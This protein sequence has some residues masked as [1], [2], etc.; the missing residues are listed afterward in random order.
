[1]ND[2]TATV[3]DIQRGSF[4]DGPGIRTTVFFKGCNLHC[5][6]CH[7]PEGLEKEPE[8]M[9]TPERCVGCGHCATATPYDADFLCPHGAKKICGRTYTLDGILREVQKDIRFYNASGGGVTL[10]GGECLLQIDFVEALLRACRE[11]GI[12]TAVD[13]AG[14]VPYE[15]FERILPYVDLFL[16]DVKC[17]D[18][19]KHRHFTGVDNKL[20]LD[21]LRRLLHAGA[22][23]CVRVPL[24]PTVNDTEEEMRA[25]KELVT[26]HGHLQGLELLPYH[27]M[28]EDKYAA[29]GKA[30]THF[31]VPSEDSVE[32]LKSILL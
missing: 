17:A 4:V 13:T 19:Q 2:L 16:Y 1:M 15:R 7:N 25:I 28:G 24:I 10:S 20:I 23:V 9:L 29:L 3:F 18:P 8:W 6:W 21:N 26:S 27:A 11:K 22:T 12:H 5:A 30:A 32:R 14:H 31:P